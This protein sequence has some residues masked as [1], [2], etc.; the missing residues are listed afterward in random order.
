MCVIQ[1]PAN[2]AGLVE[3]RASVQRGSYGRAEIAENCFTGGQW[4]RWERCIG[5]ARCASP[6]RTDRTVGAHRS[7][8]CPVTGGKQEISFR[9]SGISNVFAMNCGHVSRET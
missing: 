9:V 4:K 6:R 3:G 1:G 5:I 2:L 7:P 8:G